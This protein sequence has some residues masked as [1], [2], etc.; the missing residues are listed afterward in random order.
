M[1][2]MIRVPE[3]RSTRRG[4]IAEDLYYDLRDW[5]GCSGVFP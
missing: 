3:L 5:L 4:R 1:M 2:Q